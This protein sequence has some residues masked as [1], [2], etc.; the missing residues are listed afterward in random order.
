MNHPSLH[1]FSIDTIW[2]LLRTRLR[3]KAKKLM[4]IVQM[5][6]DQISFYGQY[7]HLRQKTVD[8]ESV[9]G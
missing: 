3:T 8:C 5:M 4:P 2:R 6:D 1:L 7:G 9:H